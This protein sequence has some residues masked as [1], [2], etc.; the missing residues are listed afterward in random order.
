MTEH[1]NSMREVL[2]SIPSTKSNDI[3]YCVAHTGRMSARFSVTM[4]STERFNKLKHK[5][6]HGQERKSASVL[7][8]Y[9]SRKSLYIHSTATFKIKQSGSRRVN[10]KCFNLF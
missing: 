5:A 9:K 4:G 10:Y 3:Q 6:S 2:G 8:Y 1:M 7:F